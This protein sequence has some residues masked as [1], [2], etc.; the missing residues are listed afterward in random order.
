MPTTQQ[1]HI[2]GA[3]ASSQ[4]GNGAST[5]SQ[6]PNNIQVKGHLNKTKQ[7]KP[8]TATAKAKKLLSKQLH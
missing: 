1:F 8:T 6:R 3:E 2:G 4:R 7:H 5:K